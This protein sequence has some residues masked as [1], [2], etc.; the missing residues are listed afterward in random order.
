MAKRLGLELLKQL[1]L[2]TRWRHLT[3]EA[4]ATPLVQLAE[5]TSPALL[6]GLGGAL[7][8]DVGIADAYSDVF[9]RSFWYLSLPFATLQLLLHIAALP[10]LRREGILRII[11]VRAPIMEAPPPA[12]SQKRMHVIPELIT[13]PLVT[14]PAQTVAPQQPVEAAPAPSAAAP[15]AAPPR[16]TVSDITE[17]RNRWVAA[18]IS[19]SATREIRCP[20]SKRLPA[21]VPQ[22]WPPGMRTQSSPSA[23]GA[24][25]S[26]SAASPSASA[27]LAL[28]SPGALARARAAA[29][30]KADTPEA[31]RT[32]S[33]QQQWLA[34][35]EQSDD[36]AEARAMES[37]GANAESPSGEHAL[38]I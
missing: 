3:Y 12:A 32:W 8:L 6:F 33:Q 23:S 26:A 15:A 7:D 35:L 2:P 10:Q 16:A 31:S 29:A 38:R 28:T 27:A 13:S 19:F 5:A 37:N 11:D 34:A 30:S 18:R 36:R 14:I 25:P 21:P 24:S 17:Q 22:G 4:H 20:P 1:A 9:A